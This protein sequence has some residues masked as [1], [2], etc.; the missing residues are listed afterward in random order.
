L[1]TN[2]LTKNSKQIKNEI[3]KAEAVPGNV[4][5]KSGGKKWKQ[6]SLGI[7]PI[8]NGKTTNYLSQKGELPENEGTE[9]NQS[10]EENALS[11]LQSRT[12]DFLE[13]LPIQPEPSFGIPKINFHSSVKTTGSSPKIKV[14]LVN[15][16]SVSAYVM[17]KGNNID[18]RRG[19]PNAFKYGNEELGPG[20][21]AGLR[22]GIKWTDRW[23]V[24]AG[25]EL[26]ATRFGDGN[27]RQILTAESINGTFGYLYRT[28]LGTVELPDEELSTQAQAGSVVG[29][30]VRESI[31]RYVLNLPLSV[32]Y[33]VWGKRFRFL[34]QVPMKLQFY[35][36]LSGYW[37]VPLLQEGHVE[38]FE[39]TGRQLTGELTKFQNLHSSL[40][41]NLGMGTELGIGKRFYV[42]LEP[43]YT[44]G[45]TSVVRDMPLRSV[46]N[47]FGVKVGTKWNVKKQ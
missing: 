13:P 42:F 7:K 41:I 43:T 6:N 24:L 47:S 34:Q 20:V 39:S 29:L 37:Q 26:E 33:D 18:V 44:Q 35:G 38:I 19:E 32:R 11:R 27:H 12:V 25:I 15:R 23:S 3:A 45:I 31:Q 8:G 1:I 14:P 5:N 9:N 21:A 28:A 16:L 36:L 40:G 22:A 2:D 4:S 46:T 30:E 10:G 17:P